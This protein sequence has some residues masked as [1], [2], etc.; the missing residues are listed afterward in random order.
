ME[1]EELKTFK[2]S[3]VGTKEGVDMITT[4]KDC[5]NEKGLIAYLE[6]LNLLRKYQLSTDLF[7]DLREKINR[8]QQV[9]KKE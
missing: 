5:Y 3:Y 2:V 4:K 6:L 7:V 8:D 9:Q 1:L